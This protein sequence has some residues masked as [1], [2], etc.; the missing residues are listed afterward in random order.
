MPLLSGVS[1][2]NVTRPIARGAWVQRLPDSITLPVP[3]PGLTPFLRVRFGSDAPLSKW[4][5]ATRSLEHRACFT[6]LLPPP[7]KLKTQLSCY[8]GQVHLWDMEVSGLGHQNE[9]G[10][11]SEWPWLETCLK[12]EAPFKRAWGGRSSLTSKSL[13]RSYWSRHGCTGALSRVGN[14]ASGKIHWETTGTLCSK[15]EGRSYHGLLA[16]HRG[17]DAGGNDLTEAESYLP[18]DVP[19]NAT[20]TRNWGWNAKYPGSSPG[21]PLSG[22]ERDSEQHR[23]S[24]VV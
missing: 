24:L 17:T 16:W 2:T 1:E 18:L 20:K 10:L 21:R 12:Q 7:A 23:E 19:C 13:A 22:L 9:R 6:H 11:G 14:S 5:E 4:G 15:T 3:Q 8:L